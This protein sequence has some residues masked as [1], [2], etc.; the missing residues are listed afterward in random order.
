MVER[1]EIFTLLRI[2]RRAPPSPRSAYLGSEY[3]LVAFMMH[4]S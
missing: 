3:L 1:G 4:W 2:I